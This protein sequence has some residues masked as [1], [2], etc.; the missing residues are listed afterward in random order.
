[1]FR[2]EA[3]VCEITSYILVQKKCLDAGGIFWGVWYIDKKM[4]SGSFVDLEFTK[5]LRSIALSFALCSRCSMDR[6]IR[7]TTLRFFHFLRWLF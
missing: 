7:L 3:S 2:R 1:M 5:F 6:C 4:Y